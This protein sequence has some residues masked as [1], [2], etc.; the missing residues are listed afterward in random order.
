MNFGC[1]VLLLAMFLPAPDASE[2]PKRPV[3]VLVTFEGKPVGG[4][5]L[6][7]QDSGSFDKLH[8]VTDSEGIAKFQ[9]TEIPKPYELFTDEDDSFSEDF[10]LESP[11]PYRSGVRVVAVRTAEW[12]MRATPRICDQLAR[13]EDIPRGFLGR[14]S[15][16]EYNRWYASLSPQEVSNCETL[17]KLQSDTGSLAPWYFYAYK[18]QTPRCVDG[19][20]NEIDWAAWY[21]ELMEESTGAHPGHCQEDWEM[22]WNSKG[23]ARVPDPPKYSKEEAE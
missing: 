4:L 5:H 8:A 7:Y 21:R 2:L 16:A 13:V 12:Q 3:P 6:V 10:I 23:Y 19:E 15:A 11:E 20:R 18:G 9:L 14:L 1:W 22:W 17:T